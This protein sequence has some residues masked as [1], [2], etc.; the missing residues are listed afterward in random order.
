M[1]FGLQNVSSWYPETI[2]TSTIISTIDPTHTIGLYE[3]FVKILSKAETE[4]NLLELVYLSRQFRGLAA[5]MTIINN[6][7]FLA[8]ATA[9]Q[10][11]PQVTEQMFNATLNLQALQRESNIYRTDL[12]VPGNAIFA[13]L[14]FFLLIYFGTI[15]WISSA[16]YFSICMFCASSLEFIGYLARVMAHYDSAKEELFL[17]QIITLTVA[18]TFIMAAIYF[19]L[20]QFITVHGREYSIFK[21]LLFAYIFLFGDVISLLVQSGGGAYVAICTRNLKPVRPGTWMMVGGIAFQVVYM[22]LF[23]SFY[24][25][26]I[27]RIYFRA[28]PTIKFSFRRTFQLLFN[29]SKGQLLR[30]DLDPCYNP[31]FA[32]ARKRPLFNYMPV[33]ILVSSVSIYLRCIYRMV[34]L[35]QGWG[36]YLI[37]HEEYVLTL[38]ALMVFLACAFYVPFHPRFTFGKDTSISVVS[39]GVNVP[40]LTPEESVG[41]NQH[42][43]SKEEEEET[44]RSNSEKDSSPST[45]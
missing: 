25:H 7:K 19:L 22:T 20:A 13:V 23:L 40:R 26:F 18:P 31:Q 6:Q 5:S 45:F 10:D 34:E 17:C 44:R 9:T 42:R 43:E 3:T 38:D 32:F 12:S 15:A 8:T 11:F 2:P 14:F 21:P 1:S 33:A 37:T 35:S 16:P 39:E 41:R 4:T 24:I 30:Q 29:T 28:N 36:G 27:D